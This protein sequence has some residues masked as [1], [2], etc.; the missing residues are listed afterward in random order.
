METKILIREPSGVLVF[1]NIG[2]MLNPRWRLMRNSCHFYPALLVSSFYF[3][4]KQKVTRED[5][6]LLARKQLSF[7]QCLFIFFFFLSRRLFDAKKCLS[8][9]DEHTALPLGYLLYEQNEFNPFFISSCKRLISWYTVF[10]SLS[11]SFL[12]VLSTLQ[13]FEGNEPVISNQNSKFRKKT[14]CAND[15]SVIEATKSSVT[16][17]CCPFF[18]KKLWVLS[19]W[20]WLSVENWR[21]QYCVAHQ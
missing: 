11:T 13:V 9:E 18:W 8:G 15:V 3:S 21:N 2:R 10:D 20:F 12:L 5:N 4:L 6:S 14:G 7:N 17:K 1:S 19:G 16:S